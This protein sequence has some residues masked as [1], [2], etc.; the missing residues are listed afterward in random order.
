MI[1]LSQYMTNIE[2]FNKRFPDNMPTISSIHY[3]I[4]HLYVNDYHMD[5]TDLMGKTK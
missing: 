4:M 3:F 5:P 2:D 1:H